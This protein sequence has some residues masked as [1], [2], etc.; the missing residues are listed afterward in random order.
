MVKQAQAFRHYYYVQNEPIGLSDPSGLEIEV[1]GSADFKKKVAA[2]LKDLKS[3]PRGESLVKYLVDSS[4]THTIEETAGGN[5]C[6][7]DSSWYNFLSFFGFGAGSVISF[8]PLSMTG[9]RDSNGS[10][11]RP[12]F[13]GLGH[14]MGHSEAFDQGTQSFDRGSKAPGTTPPSETNSILRENEI[15]G[16]H[17][18][19][20]RPSYY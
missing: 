15:R 19:P 12:P 7:S 3:K 2:A 10:Y 5:Q 13:V 1:S 14:E 17:G 4:S 11:Q 18:I 8:N 6:R 20:L 16:E 9:G